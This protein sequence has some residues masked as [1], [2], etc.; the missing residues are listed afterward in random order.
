MNRF[1]KNRAVKAVC[2]LLCTLMMGGGNSMVW[3]QVVQPISLLEGEE[4]KLVS[5]SFRDAPVAVVL[6]HYAEIT[7]RT[8]IQSPGVPQVLISLRGQQRLTESEFLQAIESVLQMNNITLVPLGEKFLKVVPSGEL[9]THG[10][11]IRRDPAYGDPLLDPGTDT[12]DTRIFE[13]RNIEY[14]EVQ[15][16]LESMKRPFGRIQPMERTNSLLVMD[17]AA[18]LQRMA[19]IIEYIDVPLERRVETRVYEI[20]HAEAGQVAARLNELVQEAQDAGR[21]PGA[22]PAGV[23]SVRGII[24]P[25]QVQQPEPPPGAQGDADAMDAASQGIVMQPVKI[26]SDERTNI[27]IVI[28]RPENFA[29]FDNI[30][31]ILD[32]SIEPNFLLEVIPLEFA[33]AGEIAGILNDFV[34][35]ATADAQ[36]GRA[37]AARTAAGAAGTDPAARATAL[38]DLVRQRLAERET[39]ARAAAR[40][41]Q[42][43]SLTDE[44]GSISANT[45]ILSDQ[46]TNS[47]L[48]MGRRQDIEALRRVV[49]SLDVMLAQVLIE[50]VILEVNLN[51][52]LEY[53]IDWL[54]RSFT[55][56]DVE[57]VGPGGGLTVRDP[58]FA[59]GGAQN[60][61]GGP[62]VDGSQ[63]SRENAPDLFS[64]GSL[65]YFLT[66]FDLNLDAVVRLAASSS[67]ARILST[68]VIVT[69][70]NT[71]ARILVGESRPVVTSTSTTAGGVAR[72]TFQYQEIGIS[73]NVTPRINPQNFVVMEITQTADN[74]G[75]FEVIDGNNVPI[76]TRREL[77]AQIAVEDRGTI[78]LGGLVSSDGQNSTTKVPILGDIP[79]LGALFRSE[80]K[81]KNRTELLVLIT[82]YVLST[83]M[84]VSREARRLRDRSFVDETTWEGTWSDSKLLRPDNLRDEAE[85]RPPL[86]EMVMAKPTDPPGVLGRR[87]HE[88]AETA[89][90]S[91]PVPAEA[92][93][94]L[95]DVVEMEIEESVPHAAPTPSAPVPRQETVVEEEVWRPVPAPLPEPSAAPDREPVAGPLAEPILEPLPRL[96]PERV[97]EPEPEPEPEAVEPPTLPRPTLRPVPTPA[98]PVL[99]PW[100]PDDPEEEALP[101]LSGGESAD[102]IPQAAVEMEPPAAEISVQPLEEPRPRARG[103]FSRLFGRGTPEPSTESPPDVVP[104]AASTVSEV[105]A[106]SDLYAPVP[107][108]APSAP[109]LEVVEEEL[110]TVSAASI[111]EP[112]VTPSI[113][114]LP[115]ET[116]LVA[117]ETLELAM[118]RAPSEPDPE[119]IRP[120]QSDAWRRAPTESGTG[121]SP[122][123]SPPSAAPEEMPAPAE[124]PVAPEA[125]ALVDAPSREPEP[126]VPTRRRRP[127]AIV[128]PAEASLPIRRRVRDSAPEAVDVPEEVDEMPI[129]EAAIEPPLEPPVEAFIEPPVEEPVAPPVVAPVEVAPPH[130]DVP[131]PVPVPQPLPRAATV[132]PEALPDV[133]V[134]PPAPASVPTIVRPT[135]RT[136]RARP[137][138]SPE[139]VD[140]AAAPAEEDAAPRPR[141]RRLEEELRA[142][143]SE[144]E[145]EQWEE[146]EAPAIRAPEPAAETPSETLRR[147]LPD[148]PPPVRQ[149]PPARSLN[150]D[151]LE[152]PPPLQ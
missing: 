75:G 67:D 105:A 71:E 140:A 144:A 80:R 127:E 53:G 41:S 124:A 24:R 59:F 104:V 55:V 110:I 85:A 23:R 10:G 61:R 143:V 102:A 99:P 120:V 77:Q 123:I 106:V 82:P 142:V 11:E 50:A 118:S 146:R 86:T 30:V 151:D 58:V 122:A 152:A 16:I 114:D 6:D 27:L 57:R 65:S 2:L 60:L 19:D 112:E 129:V 74:V 69:T 33:D 63:V 135:I 78:V 40:A 68:P 111:Q 47:I 20:N 150:G 125:A 17:T 101:P 42:T 117:E 26:V 133:S 43:D 13:F 89:A 136:P 21:R 12:M 148:V 87:S 5:L 25:G 109:S 52:G 49:E 9:G 1:R 84:D 56:S 28:T 96:A 54:Q 116:V 44:I 7:G 36:S 132:T 149:V 37:G 141:R 79:L 48:L 18:N 70:D 15:P 73:L 128:R 95:Q 3:A 90:D 108:R 97:P 119:T 147:E 46:R 72:N 115:V 137:T 51:E 93:S 139:A 45:R 130:A 34:G 66:F 91:A 83:P 92:R 126:T 29:F 76:I 103:F 22:Q 39:A 121:P 138:A 62:F 100:Q 88:A 64:A 131:A 4:E 35:A 94:D 31:T 107:R 8:M 145:S 98:V 38:Q 14:T 134:P 32:R 81:Q 113:P